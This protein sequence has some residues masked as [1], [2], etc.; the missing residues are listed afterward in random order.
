MLIG[1]SGAAALMLN[2]ITVSVCAFARGRQSA[3]R[4][5]IMD[6]LLMFFNV[7]STVLPQMLTRM[8]GHVVRW[9]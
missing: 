9:L 7:F 4:Q 3:E 8:T 6:F 5:T 1:L 2:H